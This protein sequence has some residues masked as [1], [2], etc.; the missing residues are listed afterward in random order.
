MR[1]CLSILFLALTVV[2]CT[3]EPNRDAFRS[4]APTF[5]RTFETTTTVRASNGPIH[6]VLPDGTV[7]D[8]NLGPNPP[9]EIGAIFAVLFADTDEGSSMLLGAASPQGPEVPTH[10]G[11]PH[12]Q[13][14][15]VFYVPIGNWLFRFFVTPDTKS[16]LGEEYE[17]I[18]QSSIVAGTFLEFPVLRVSPPFRWSIDGESTS[19]TQVLYYSFVVRSGCGELAVE[20]SGAD[21]VQFIPIP[22]TNRAMLPWSDEGGLIEAY[23][24]LRDEMRSLLDSASV[25]R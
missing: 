15:S 18:I 19:H 24:P 21:P 16:V 6:G 13:G 4:T 22:R 5:P 12:W 1:P 14:D 9:E 10:F 3:S 20:C 11:A 25:P 17:A 23:A 2:G 8:L 7:Y